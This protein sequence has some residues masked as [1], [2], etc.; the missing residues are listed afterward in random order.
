MDPVSAAL[1]QNLRRFFVATL[2]STMDYKVCLEQYPENNIVNKLD[3]I[4]LGVSYLENQTFY[5]FYLLFHRMLHAMNLAWFLSSIKISF[6]KFCQYLE[7]LFE[8][9][10]YNVSHSPLLP[11]NRGKLGNSKNFNH[12][13]QKLRYWFGEMLKKALYHRKYFN[14]TNESNFGHMISF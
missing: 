5:N 14:Q 3:L 7:C 1:P 12:W 13:L 6:D 11:S 2:G 10:W 9:S 4:I 8:S